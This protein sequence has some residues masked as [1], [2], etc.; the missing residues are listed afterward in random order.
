M[1]YEDPYVY[2]IPIDTYQTSET[3]KKFH[4]TKYNPINV[5]T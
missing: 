3:D 5:T 2:K 1:T 4:M